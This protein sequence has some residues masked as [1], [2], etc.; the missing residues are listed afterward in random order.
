MARLRPSAL[1]IQR[2]QWRDP[3]LI[4]GMLLVAVSIIA[5]AAFATRVSQ[6]TPV[7]AVR[8]DVV[9]GDRL[10]A[11][12]FVSVDVR[13]GDSAARYVASPSEIPEGAIALDS[14]R[15]GELLALSSVG[16]PESLALRPVVIDVTSTVTRGVKAGDTV[17]IW[18]TTTPA[19]QAD[20]SASAQ[21]LFEGA[22]VRHV[23][24][25]AGIGSQ[26]GAIEV[27]VPRDDVPRILEALAEEGAMTVIAVPQASEV[28]P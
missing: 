9:A 20:A 17:E 8:A 25:G 7:L 3:R 21:L 12:N 5:G 2:P 16:Q 23:H 10:S 14:M 6:T 27:L 26:R 18:H 19:R 22:V 28:T 24:E 15:A 13:L 1:R 4:I 11:D